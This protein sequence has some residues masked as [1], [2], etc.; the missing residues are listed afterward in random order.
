MLRMTTIVQVQ[1][2]VSMNSHNKQRA[3]TTKPQSSRS[4][5]MGFLRALRVLGGEKSP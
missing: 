1:N 2:V 4:F 5:L 3:M